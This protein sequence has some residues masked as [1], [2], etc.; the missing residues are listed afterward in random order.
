M[1]PEHK[2]GGKKRGSQLHQ[3][4]EKHSGPIPSDAHIQPL[5]KALDF[6][7]ILK[8]PPLFV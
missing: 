8:F 2:E 1:T 7:K 5:S 3:D 4:V 6:L